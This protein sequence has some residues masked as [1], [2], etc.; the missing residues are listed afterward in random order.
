M[1]INLLNVIFI[2]E[3]K[4]NLDKFIENKNGPRFYELIGIVSIYMNEKRYVS[5]C[6]SPVDQQWY[7][8]DNDTVSKVDFNVVINNHNNNNFIP[9]L[10]VYN[11]SNK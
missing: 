9:C 5:C 7:Y 1:D 10:L 4:I 8:Y 3:E 2:V 6:K 11:E